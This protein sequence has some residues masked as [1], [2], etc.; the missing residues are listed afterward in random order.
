M[1][2]VNEDI[3]HHSPR[4]ASRAPVSVPSFLRRLRAAGIRRHALALHS[5]SASGIIEGEI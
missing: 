1:P 2:H 3:L 5:D 4:C